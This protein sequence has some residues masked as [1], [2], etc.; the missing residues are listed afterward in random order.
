M[1]AQDRRWS[2]SG[3]V[4]LAVAVTAAVVAGVS[5]FVNAYA[6]AHG[7]L[8]LAMFA[9]GVRAGALLVLPL[10][11]AW[12]LVASCRLLRQA[13]VAE[14]RITRIAAQNLAAVQDLENKLGDPGY[15]AARMRLALAQAQLTHGG[16]HDGDGAAGGDRRN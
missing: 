2:A 5:E 1:N 16:Q 12:V 7:D 15:I 11:A 10:P 14:L 13:R 8:Q 3:W 4:A 9:S 6:W